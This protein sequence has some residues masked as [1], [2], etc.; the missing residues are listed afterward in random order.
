MNKKTAFSEERAHPRHGQNTEVAIK[1]FIMALWGVSNCISIFRSS[2][3][4][5][6]DKV[7]QDEHFSLSV[8][9]LT[10]TMHPK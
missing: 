8:P 4:L 3:Q 10:Y 7:E 5:F 6:K 1:L 2:Y 9:G